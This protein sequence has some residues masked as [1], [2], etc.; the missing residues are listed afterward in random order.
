MGLP[1]LA[2]GKINP[3]WMV[4]PSAG[5]LVGFIVSSFTVGSL[6]DKFQGGFFRNWLLLSMNEMIILTLGALWLGSV[7][8]WQNSISMGVIPFIPGALIKISIATLMSTRVKK[9]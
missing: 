1:V 7:V 8:G 4:G 3:A 6:W 9:L 2:S 5:Y